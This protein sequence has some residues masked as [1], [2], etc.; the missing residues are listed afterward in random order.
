MVI[1][2]RPATQDDAGPACDV[3]HRS[4]QAFGMEG[5]PMQKTLTG[6]DLAARATT[7]SS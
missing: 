4:I 3:L 6:T 1:H 5:D 7:T 2:A